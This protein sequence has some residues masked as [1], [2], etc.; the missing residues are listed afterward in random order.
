MAQRAAGPSCCSYNHTPFNHT[1]QYPGMG[2]FTL[3]ISQSVVFI[4][5]LKSNSLHFV[6]KDN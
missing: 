1:V 6:E 3:S 2:Q 4:L 5:F